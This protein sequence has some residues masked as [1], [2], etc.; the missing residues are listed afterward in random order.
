[1]SLQTDKISRKEKS[2]YAKKDLY[3]L[4]VDM[5]K[6]EKCNKMKKKN[7]ALEEREV[8]HLAKINIL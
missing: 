7:Q 5:L 1:M 2:N 8:H 4:D 6:T 3:W